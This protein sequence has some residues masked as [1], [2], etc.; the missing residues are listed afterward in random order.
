[1]ARPHGAIAV[2]PL[3]FSPAGIAPDTTLSWWVKM[4]IVMLVLHF[5]PAGVAPDKMLF[6]VK[7]QMMFLLMVLT[8]QCYPAGIAPDSLSWVFSSPSH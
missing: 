5:S 6:W 4:Q 2:L 1:M 8:L 3:Q 7:M